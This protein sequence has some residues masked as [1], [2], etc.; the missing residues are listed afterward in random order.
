MRIR[1]AKNLKT[2]SVETQG[3]GTEG[4]QADLD[5]M[6]TNMIGDGANGLT[7]SDVEVGWEDEKTVLGWIKDFNASLMTYA[8]KR[9]PLYGTWEEQLDMMYHGTWEKHVSKVKKDIPK[10]GK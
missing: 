4:N 9:K 6:Q 7:P 8:D 1:Y 3:E 2:G 5:V 10:G